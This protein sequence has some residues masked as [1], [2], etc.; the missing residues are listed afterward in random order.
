M[1]ISV[2]L[3]LGLWIVYGLFKPNVVIVIANAVSIV[4][5]AFVIYAK[6]KYTNN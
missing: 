5:F 6:I 3:G 1:L 4:A 2:S